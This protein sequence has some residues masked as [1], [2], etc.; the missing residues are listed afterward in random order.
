MKI[1]NINLANA[2][3]TNEHRNKSKST[4]QPEKIQS[5]INRGV[6][7]QIPQLSQCCC[8][9]ESEGR[10]EG[11]RGNAQTREEVSRADK[12][13]HKTR[14]LSPV[15]LIPTSLFVTSS[16][17]HFSFSK[18]NNMN[19]SWRGTRST[20]RKKNDATSGAGKRRG[21]EAGEK[22]E[23]GGGEEGRRRGREG[24]RKEDKGGRGGR[25]VGFKEDWHGNKETT[26][27]IAREVTAGAPRRAIK[28]PRWESLTRPSSACHN[29]NGFS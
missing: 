23:G 2:Q 13:V 7:L 16:L 20:N 11:N 5:H 27:L 8:S 6:A 1:R 3:N 21:K 12:C 29:L 14:S 9:G 28:D 24:I 15:K 25:K 19:R 22:R 18:K 10:K 26:L 4:L 17:V